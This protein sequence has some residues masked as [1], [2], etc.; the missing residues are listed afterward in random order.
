MLSATPYGMPVDD[1]AMENQSPC[2]AAP[3]SAHSP[4]AARPR[5]ARGSRLAAPHAPAPWASA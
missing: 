2:G 3:Q 5:P 4:P 1:T